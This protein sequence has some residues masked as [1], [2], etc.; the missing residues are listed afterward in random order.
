MLGF[1]ECSP[2]RII[3]VYEITRGHIKIKMTWTLLERTSRAANKRNLTQERL[4]KD[5][6]LRHKRIMEASGD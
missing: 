1:S 6:K 4:I 2:A 3:S 5:D